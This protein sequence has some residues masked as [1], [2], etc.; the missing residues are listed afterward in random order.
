VAARPDAPPLWRH[1][2]PPAPPT[3]PLDGLRRADRAIVSGGML[4]LA[5]ALR[6]AERGEALARAFAAGGDEVFAP[7]DRHHIA[8]AA[9]R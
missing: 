2:A 5:L 1:T 8:G 7:I 4:G 9:M 6:A 3:R